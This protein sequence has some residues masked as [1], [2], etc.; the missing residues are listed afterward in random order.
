MKTYLALFDKKATE[1]C[2]RENDVEKLVPKMLK[3][4]P[5]RAGG[6]FIV[7]MNLKARYLK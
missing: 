7:G 6:H 2:G 1:L 5:K 4:L 3:T